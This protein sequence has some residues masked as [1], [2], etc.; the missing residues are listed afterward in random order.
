MKAVKE[1]SM[2]M[3]QPERERSRCGE[4]NGLVVDSVARSFTVYYDLATDF[5]YLLYYRISLVGPQ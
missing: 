3:M 4:L 2:I 1:A 5:A